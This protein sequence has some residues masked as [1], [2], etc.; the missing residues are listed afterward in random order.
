[1]Q[2]V[3]WTH[4]P[5]SLDADEDEDEWPVRYFTMFFLLRNSHVLHIGGR[6][7]YLNTKQ[8]ALTLRCV[9][10]EACAL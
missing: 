8:A 5:S 7:G 9:S 6:V 10:V 4:T 1:M 3:R 2:R